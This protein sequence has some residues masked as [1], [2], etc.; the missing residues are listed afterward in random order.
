[1]YYNKDNLSFSFNS[2]DD[3]N[4]NDERKMEQLKFDLLSLNCSAL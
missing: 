4:K 1:M 2:S 3:Q